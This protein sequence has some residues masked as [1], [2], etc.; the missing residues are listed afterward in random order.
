MFVKLS[1]L[2]TKVEKKK[3]GADGGGRTHTLSRVLDFESSASA[4]S[5][6]SAT[7]GAEYKTKCGVVK[8]ALSHFLFQSSAVKWG[9]AKWLFA[10][11]AVSSL[12][13]SA[14]LKLEG[15]IFHKGMCDASAAIPVATNL[16]AVANDEDNIIRLYYND[17]TGPPV[18]QFNIESFLK[19]DPKEP[20][21]DVEGAAVVGH[22]SYWISSHGRNKNGKARP[23]RYRFFATQVAESPNGPVIRP[24]G[25]PY[26]NLLADLINEPSLQR[27]KLKEAAQLAPKEEGAFNIEGLSGSPDGSLLIGF[28]NPIP[29]GK[30]LLVPLLNPAEVVEKGAKARFGQP[31]QLNLGGLGIRSMEFVNGQYY[32]AAGPHEGVQGGKIVTWKGGDDQPVPLEIA[33]KDFSPE[34]FLFYPNQPNRMQLFSD[35]G[36]LK[37]GGVACKDLANPADMQFRTFWVTLHQ[38]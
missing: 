13:L 5:A 7:K 10:V 30:A 9:M 8:D 34:A 21:V 19:P 2:K 29:G 1:D 4:N 22:R 31:K 20:E 15:P 35:D 12:S 3:V 6:T 17:R 33:V 28:R 23:S 11:F 37:I 14:G 16:F 26:R 18:N 36:S 38:P 25:V 32:I 27:F 24:V